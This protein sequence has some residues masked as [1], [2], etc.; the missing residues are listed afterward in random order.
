[1][2]VINLDVSKVNED[3]KEILEI[4]DLIESKKELLEKYNIK[5][6]VNT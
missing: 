1:M 5:F 3:L 4:T 6:T 2:T